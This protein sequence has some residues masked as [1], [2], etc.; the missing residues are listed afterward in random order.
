[1]TKFSII[2]PVYNNENYFPMAVKSVE[3]QN[4]ENYELIIVDDGSTDKTPRIADDL[5]RKNPHIKVIH[6]ENQW[7]YNSFNNGITLAEGEYIYILNSDDRLVS[8]A[9][10]LFDQKIKKYHPDIIWTKVLAHL[11]DSK[12]NILV[13]DKYRWDRFV[14]EEKFYP[15]KKEVERAWPYFLSSKLAQNQ[16]NLYRREVMKGKLFRSDVY[17]ADTLYNID[18]A[19]AVNTA[20][21]LKEPIYYYYIYN[22]D[23]MNASVG[24]YYSYEHT[25]FNEIYILYRNL[26]QKWQLKSESYVEIICKKRMSC[27]T[28]EL[29][30]LQAVNCPLSLEEKLKF[31]FCECIDDIVRECAFLRNREEELESR[32]LSAVKELLIN[33]PINSGNK[34]YFIYELLDSLLRYEKDEKDLKKIENAVN[35]PLNPLHIG[36]IF[37]KK[38]IQGQDTE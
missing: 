9:L 5:A 30:N 18:I 2:M 22:N 8:G 25:M 28:L 37:Y 19:D 38:L 12:Q 32:I 34:M 1:M 15:T 10:T 35:H 29:K 4:Y 6:Q 13:Y 7:I 33:E 17:G 16:A 20:L 24:K 14:K 31:A 36:N 23:L 11:C 26:F 21:V 27:L 3:D